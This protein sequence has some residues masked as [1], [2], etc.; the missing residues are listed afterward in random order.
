MP[1]LQKR[2]ALIGVLRDRAES[3]TPVEKDDRTLT[4]TIIS[5]DNE[6]MRYDWFSG[7]SYIERL[8]VSGAKTER[9]NTFF[10]DHNRGVDDAIG[11]VESVR[12]DGGSLKA[13]V[14]FGSESDSILNK[15]REGILTDVSIGYSIEKYDVE[16]RSDDPDIVTVTEFSIRELSAVGIGFDTGA[17]H[18]RE[19]EDASPQISK[20][21]KRMPK[22]DV[23]QEVEVETGVTIDKERDGSVDEMAKKLAEMERK[24]AIRSTADHFGV[25]KEMTRTFVGDESKTVQDFKDALLEKRMSET[26]TIDVKVG[27]VSNKDEMLRA[28][29]D[30][31]VIKMGGTVEKPHADTDM[32]RMA[33]LGDMA[34]SVTGMSGYNKIEIAERAMVTADFPNLLLGSGNRVLE[35]EFQAAGATY[36]EIVT[37]VDVPDFRTNKDLTKGGGGKLTKLYEG[38][39][40]KEKQFA[41]GAETWAVE[42]FGNKFELTRQ[43]I[44]N[45]DLG[46]FTDMLGNFG[47]MSALTANGAVYDLLMKRN[48]YS[49][50]TM[51]DGVILFH[52]DH[53]NTASSALTA[54]TLAAGRAAMRKHKG[55]DGVTPLNIAPTYLIV[56]PDTEQ[57]AYE[58]VFSS[59]KV[60]AEKSSGVANF[61]LNSLTVIVDAEI[62][63]AQW[64]LSAPRRAVKVGYLAGT[65]RRPVL[66][67]ND[68]SLVST[69]FEG[70]FDFGVVP[71]DY[72][73]LYA[74]NGV[75]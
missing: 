11:K 16:E 45:D 18:E 60:E 14:V 50:F 55:L 62:T 72:R 20:E 71:T 21:E 22:I 58:L 39:E 69:I 40:L 15:Y 49:A 31:M 42:S 5:E 75:A 29:G 68:T 57:T 41:E 38:G 47:E 44:I 24:E 52:A 65:G 56:G 3:V 48:D 33:T 59:A 51:A 12:M 27:D 54:A 32:Y 66:K 17:K 8:D 23:D 26:P 73:G 19:A 7:D 4:F 34:K 70:I 61:H 13:D 67:V 10:K 2:E 37:E 53:S 30:A 64:F 35:G 28:M 25:D 63:G 46:A 6:G 9:L 74:G 1:Q 36:R 43:M